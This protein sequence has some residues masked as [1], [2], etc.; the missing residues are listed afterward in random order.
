MCATFAGSDSYGASAGAFEACE[1][2][3]SWKFEQWV[4]RVRVLK[5]V[6]LCHYL[7]DAL[8]QT[9]ALG[10]LLRLLRTCDCC[11]VD[12]DDLAKK[13]PNNWS[14]ELGP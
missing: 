13:R 11:Q 1:A 7:L 6:E 12:L 5:F 4:A 8:P 3:Q 9:S 10:G 2:G 14:G